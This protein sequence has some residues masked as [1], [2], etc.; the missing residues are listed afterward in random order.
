MDEK[1]SFLLPFTR[2]GENKSYFAPTLTYECKSIPVK[3][4]MDIAFYFICLKNNEIYR[5]W[6]DILKDGVSL[7]DDSWDRDK[8][9]RAEDPNS[10]PYEIAVGLNVNLPDIPFSGEGIHSIKAKLYSASSKD[11]PIDIKE[12]FFKVTQVK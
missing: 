3:V 8:Y 10:K 11:T 1:I 6:F 12:V 5:L 4:A 7:I 2:V 9:F